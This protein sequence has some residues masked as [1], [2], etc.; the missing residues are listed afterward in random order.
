MRRTNWQKTRWKWSLDFN[1]YFA[2]LFSNFIISI[3]QFIL[4]HFIA[5][6]FTVTFYTLYFKTFRI[7]FITKY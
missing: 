6:K 3:L 5:F 1:Y 4:P 2:F 7:P